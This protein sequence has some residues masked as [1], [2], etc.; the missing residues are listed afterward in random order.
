MEGLHHVCNIICFLVDV[1]GIELGFILLI[2]S[3]I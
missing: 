3:I 2:D 1:F